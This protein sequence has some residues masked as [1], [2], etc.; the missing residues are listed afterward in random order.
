MLLE[1]QYQA[2]FEEIPAIVVWLGQGRRLT[3]LNELG[4]AYFGEEA[5]GCPIEE[6]LVGGEEVPFPSFEGDEV[7]RLDLWHRREN[8]RLSLISWTGKGIKNEEGVTEKQVVIGYDITDRFKREEALRNYRTIV[9]NTNDVV[10]TLD[11]HGRITYGNKAFYG[12]W[13]TERGS[14]IGRSFKELVHYGNMDKLDELLRDDVHGY[15][16]IEDEE[17]QVMGKDDEIIHLEMAASRIYVGNK[18]VGATVI[19]RNVTQWKRSEELREETEEQF[20]QLVENSPDG[21]IIEQFDRIIYANRAFKRMVSDDTPRELAGKSLLGFW[22]P[23]SR[24]VVV[25]HQE[26]AYE[27]IGIPINFESILSTQTGLLKFVEISAIVIPYQGEWS[28]LFFVRDITERKKLEKGLL[29]AQKMEAVGTLTGGI[30]HDFKNI[31]AAIK[32]YAELLEFK[33]EDEGALVEDVRQID[34]A[35]DRAADLIHRLLAFGRKLEPQLKPMN[36]NDALED[37]S[38]I[39]SRTI[40]KTIRIETRLA[41]SPWTVMADRGQIGQVLLNLG[42]NARD[43]MPDGGKLLFETMNVAL[44]KKQCETYPGLKPGRYVMILVRDT[45]VG[46]S[47]AVASRIFEPFFTTKRPGEGTGLGL[48]MAYGILKQHKGNI[49]VE[50]Q[51]R[52]GSNFMVYLPVSE[53]DTSEIAE[54]ELELRTGSGTI[55]VVDDEENLRQVLQRALENMGYQVISAATT[56]EAVQQFVKNKHIIDLVIADYMMPEMD[57]FRFTEEILKIEPGTKVLIMSGQQDRI[58]VDKAKE[59]GALDLLIK[60]FSMKK[61]SYILEATIKGQ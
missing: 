23:E 47:S 16:N 21:I 36:V 34:Q 6:F 35:V 40:P 18:F 57:G 5:V 28:L 61:L 33:L 43:A 49:Y 8:G 19:A 55:L 2:V 30:A 37:V 51:P 22:A 29:A 52:K 41:A 53:W 39:L 26:I 46:M 12:L 20:R 48:A 14:F 1:D 15:P 59:I 45:G 58:S 3:W 50:S 27:H 17:I 54:S 56:K 25:R 44:D 11:K 24:D 32:G 60:P 42:I 38:K 4:K 10:L 7:L 9:E 31:L 13:G